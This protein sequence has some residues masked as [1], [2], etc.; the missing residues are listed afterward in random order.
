MFGEEKK[1]YVDA[2]HRILCCHIVVS[3]LVSTIL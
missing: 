3:P 2:I 1:K